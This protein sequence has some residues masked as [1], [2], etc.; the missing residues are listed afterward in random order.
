MQDVLGVAQGAVLIGGKLL[1]LGAAQGLFGADIPHHAHQRVQIA[2]F[3]CLAIG[4]LA[5][6]GV[7]VVVG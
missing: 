4:Q 2:A 1:A 5:G 6:V 3:Q 7:R